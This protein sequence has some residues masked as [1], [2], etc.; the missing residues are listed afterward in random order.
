MATVHVNI[1][2]NAPCIVSKAT[3][4]VFKAI[5][6][7]H[8]YAAKKCISCIYPCPKHFTCNAKQFSGNVFQLRAD[9]VC[10]EFGFS[11]YKILFWIWRGWSG[12]GRVL[13]LAPDF[14][15]VWATLIKI[16][17]G[18]TGANS[19][20]NPLMLFACSVDTRIHINRSHLLARVLCG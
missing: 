13:W 7:W 18:R 8:T 6:F 10:Q 12:H 5:L 20:T 19:N 9:V 17:T 2:G 3:S 15:G 11:T 4:N 14:L 16:H 1:H